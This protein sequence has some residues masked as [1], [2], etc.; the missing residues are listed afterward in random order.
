MAL[1][2]EIVD[3]NFPQ[4]PPGSISEG[5][6]QR[7]RNINFMFKEGSWQT[8]IRYCSLRQTSNV[9]HNMR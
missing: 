5:N 4:W 8:G 9:G 7:G 3:T 1:S 2:S 6:N